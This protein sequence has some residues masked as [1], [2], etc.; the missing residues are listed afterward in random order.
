MF[1]YTSVIL[2]LLSLLISC[3]S[4]TKKEVVDKPTANITVASF[5]EFEQVLNNVDDKTYVINFWA[6]WCAPC[7]KELPYFEEI[8]NNYHSDKVEVI[9]VS[10]DFPDKIESKLLPFINKKKLKSKVII[11]DAP[12]ENEWIP[13]IDESWS[14]SIP[15]TIIYNKN[16]RTFYGHSFT[17][18]ELFTELEKFIKP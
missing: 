2:I 8:T 15:A 16:K 11:L 18:D 3:K 1:K 4:E 5:K 9:L 6:T 7:V 12:N 13:K 17:R 10:L 14:G